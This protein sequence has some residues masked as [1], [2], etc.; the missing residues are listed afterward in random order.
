M[1]AALPEAK[2][3]SIRAWPCRGVPATHGPGHHAAPCTFTQ[4]WPPSKGKQPRDSSWSMRRATPAPE[5]RPMLGEAWTA[6]AAVLITQRSKAAMPCGA[7]RMPVRLLGLPVRLSG[8]WGIEACPAWVRREAAAAGTCR[9]PKAARL[10]GLESALSN[11]PP[12]GCAGLLGACQA[13]SMPQTTMVAVCCVMDS[14]A[15]TGPGWIHMT[16]A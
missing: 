6:A 15:P 2:M 5:P 3:P 14:L 9:G 4:L 10:G 1:L 11:C 12:A 16:H 8:V 7:V 13:A